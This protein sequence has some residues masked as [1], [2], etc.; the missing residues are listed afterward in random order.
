MMI[1]DE[2]CIDEEQCHHHRT[3]LVYVV[4]PEVANR[5]SCA[6]EIYFVYANS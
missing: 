5:I 1:R 2:Q 3:L 6:Y 4:R